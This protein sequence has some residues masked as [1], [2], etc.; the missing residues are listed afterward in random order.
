M[1]IT[2]VAGGLVLPG[3]LETPTFKP[4]LPGPGKPWTVEASWEAIVQGPSEDHCGA[5][6]G[7]VAGGPCGRSVPVAGCG[8][9]TECVSA[10][11]VGET[12]DL[13]E[14]TR[15]ADLLN[16]APHFAVGYRWTRIPPAES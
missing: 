7:Y 11:I 13:R 5:C 15:R 10:Q 12:W 2:T 14:A 9:T 6:G 8:V 3:Q 16:E 4:Y 1:A